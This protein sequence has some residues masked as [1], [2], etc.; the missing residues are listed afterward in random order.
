MLL[1]ESSRPIK[2]ITITLIN[3]LL[4]FLIFMV[5][6]QAA[7]IDGTVTDE[8][9]GEPITD[10]MVTVYYFENETFITSTTTN[11]TGNFS[12][13]SLSSDTYLLNIEADGYFNSSWIVELNE[14]GNKNDSYEYGSEDAPSLS[15][16]SGGDLGSNERA[17]DSSS[18]LAFSL[19]PN[20]EGDQGLQRG[21]SSQNPLSALYNYGLMITIALVISL[22]MY[23]KIKKENLLKNAI[24][25][26]I[27]EYIKENPGKHYR[28][29]LNG[30]EIPMGVLSYHLNRLEKAQFIRSR[31]DGLYRRFYT[32]GFKADIQ[33]FLSETQESI[34]SVIKENQ[35]ISQTQI[36]DKVGV[37]RKVVNYHVGILRKAGIIFTESNGRESACYTSQPKSIA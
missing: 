2:T 18:E 14:T 4:F 3:L 28:A 23:S 31:Q 21:G 16:V 33:F 11:S 34:V 5:N 8:L 32:K 10:A 27:F 25:S 9:S 30:L 20:P 13:T 22:V 1:K 26:R 19:S 24:R 7:S 6:I 12:I 36:A 35:G 15:I 37:S 29:I 17:F